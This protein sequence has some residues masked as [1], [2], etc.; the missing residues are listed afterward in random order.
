METTNTTN[1]VSV[2]MKRNPATA[3][4]YVHDPAEKLHNCNSTLCLCDERLMIRKLGVLTSLYYG[5]YIYI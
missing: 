5:I 3:F 2:A 4:Q 1:R